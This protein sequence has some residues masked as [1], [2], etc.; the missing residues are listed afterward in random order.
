LHAGGEDIAL[1]LDLALHGSDQLLIVGL[2]RKARYG[3]PR[4]V[5]KM[6]SGSLVKDSQALR[7]ELLGRHYFLHSRHTKDFNT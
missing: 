5:I 6:P 4:F 1:D 7:L 3:R 2:G